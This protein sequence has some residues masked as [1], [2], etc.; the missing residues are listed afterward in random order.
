MTLCTRAVRGADSLAAMAAANPLILPEGGGAYSATGAEGG[1]RVEEGLRSVDAM[2]G[3]PAGEGGR[4][5]SKPSFGHCA[6]S[7]VAAALRECG[8]VDV[9][10]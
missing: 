2:C 4:T 10:H 8:V 7:G 9:P 1:V 3:G 5:P 6:V